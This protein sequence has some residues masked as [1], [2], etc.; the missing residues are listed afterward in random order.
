[1]MS[2]HEAKSLYERGIRNPQSLAPDI[3]TLRDLLEKEGETRLYATEAL[4]K[5]AYANPEV[6]HEATTELERVLTESDRKQTKINACRIAGYTDASE[7]KGQ[8]Q[9]LTGD[10]SAEVRKAAETAL[11]NLKEQENA[12]SER[13]SAGDPENNEEPASGGDTV[14]YR[15]DESNQSN[16]PPK[17]CTSCGTSLQGRDIEN[18]CPDCGFDLRD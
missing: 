8:L 18:F 10:S 15:E 7:L 14:L 12:G 5:L 11:Q 4:R 16:L 17:F 13:L 3:G 9:A 2:R 6:A 1:M